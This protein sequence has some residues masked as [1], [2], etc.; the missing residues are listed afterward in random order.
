MT[1][2]GV[3]GT[4]KFPEDGAAKRLVAAMRAL[5][6]RPG[7]TR[8][9][10]DLDLIITHYAYGLTLS[11]YEQREPRTH[12]SAILSL[13]RHAMTL[14]RAQ[15]AIRAVADADDQWLIG[16]CTSMERIGEKDGVSLT[17]EA[18]PVEASLF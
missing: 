9:A 16:A 8:S 14:G 13:L 4:Q 7:N 17:R 15:S 2:L 1:G 11:F 6:N 18:D 3:D 5:E 10:S 12:L